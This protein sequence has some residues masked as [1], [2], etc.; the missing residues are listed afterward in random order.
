MSDETSE[1]EQLALELYEVHTEIQRL[2]KKKA[3]LKDKLDP[4]MGEGERVGDCVEKVVTNRL[5]V[6]AQLLGEL[7]AKHG[8]AVVKRAVNTAELR[9]LMKDDP[10]LDQSIPRK[11]SVSL[12][13]G[14]KWGG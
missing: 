13:V 10:E 7:E 9:R 11:R 5:N 4:L 12:R 8:P 1:K 14:D 6:G 3:Y 2:E